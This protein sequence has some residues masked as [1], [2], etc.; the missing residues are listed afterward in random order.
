MQAASVVS[1]TIAPRGANLNT[2]GQQQFTAQVT[3]TANTAVTWSVQEQGDGQIDAT[4]RYTAP[5]TAGIFHV[6]A[7]RCPF[8]KFTTSDA[9]ERL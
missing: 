3:G 5:G 4:G 7:T 8:H 9:G 1:V 6:V 2:G